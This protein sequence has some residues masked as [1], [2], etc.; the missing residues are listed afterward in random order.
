MSRLLQVLIAVVGLSLTTVLG[1]ASER[2][3]DLQ[4]KHALLSLFSNSLSVARETCDPDMVL[5]AQNALDDLKYVNENRLLN[6]VAG[7]DADFDARVAVYQERLDNINDTVT[8]GSCTSGAL[9]AAPVVGAQPGILAAP[10]PRARAAEPLAPAESAPIAQ[11]LVAQ[12][13]NLDLR[14]ALDEGTRRSGGAAASTS[15]RYYAVVASYSVDSRN[16]YDER[17][18]VSEHYNQ[19]RAAVGDTAEVQVFRT[20][21]S[22]HF[23]IVLVPDGFTRE[24]AR[25]LVAR[26]R[27]D[28]LAADA[29]VQQERNWTRC[30]NPAAIRDENACRAAVRR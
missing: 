8:S 7:R 2:N 29:F 17:L 4:A 20:Q 27:R 16:T 24:N 30:A 6:R 1:L 11:E 3:Q 22:N 19:I 15:G 9:A 25:D 21:V 5:F 23:A 13:Q 18:G 28:N 26:A 12:S 14:R 10:A